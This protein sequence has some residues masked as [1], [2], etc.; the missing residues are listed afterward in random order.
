MAS[1]YD[2]KRP[3]ATIPYAGVRE[4]TRQYPDYN[5]ITAAILVEP[6]D[7]AKKGGSR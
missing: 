2:A 7:P 4:E 6:S 3:A 5:P 1:A